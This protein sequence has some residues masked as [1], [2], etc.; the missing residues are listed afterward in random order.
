MGEGG[1]EMAKIMLTLLM[2]SPLVFTEL[3]FCWHRWGHSLLLGLS[4]LDPPLRIPSKPEGGW[5]KIV[6]NVLI[7]ALHIIGNGER[8]PMQNCRTLGQHLLAEK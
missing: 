1:S 7:K 8:N 3:N 4:M 6:E 5:D 2:D